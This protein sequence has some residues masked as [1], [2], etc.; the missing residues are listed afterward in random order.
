MYTTRQVAELLQLSPRQIREYARAGILAPSRTPRG[1]QFHFQDLVVLRTAVRLATG[2]DMSHRRV[3][4]TLGKLRHQLP[5]ERSLTEIGIASV[6]NGV[7]VQDGTDVWEPETG[8]M[9][10]NFAVHLDP[11]GHATD[12]EPSAGTVVVTQDA[13]DPSTR[14]AIPLGRAEVIAQGWFE[15]GCEQ[16]AEGD[17]AAR[18]SYQR[19]IDL[20][21]GLADARVNLGRLLQ[22]DR[23][24][25]Q[26]IDQYRAALAAA[27]YHS[28]AAFNLGVAL[29]A[30]RRRDEAAEAYA[31][32]IDLDPDLADAH[33]NLACLHESAGEATA[34]LRHFQ[35]YKKL[36]GRF[37][38]TTS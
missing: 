36:T 28:T 4:R 7:I 26:A 11:P 24:L 14:D 31:H 38:P 5:G 30:A 9:H 8:Q 12:V 22:A 20:D 17:P 18:T 2:D 1:Y 3:R 13:S 19:A 6:G 23:C 21:P 16:E 37:R 25:D 35:I 32:A 10:L 34:A 33:Y 15:L 27:P 29:Q